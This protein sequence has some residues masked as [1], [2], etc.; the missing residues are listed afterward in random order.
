MK[1][2]QLLITLLIALFLV[3]GNLFIITQ[4]VRYL[5]GLGIVTVSVSDLVAV[6]AFILSMESLVFTFAWNYWHFHQTKDIHQPSPHL[7]LKER[8]VERDLQ[9]ALFV[10]DV[11]NR[12]QGDLS[13]RK[14]IFKGLWFDDER[15][16]ELEDKYDTI[17]PNGHATLRQKL[18]IPDSG[19]HILT[20]QFDM[21]RVIYKDDID[22][23]VS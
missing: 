4:F 3:L 9:S 12:G 6:A 8:I 15:I 7:K 17:E 16:Y 5:I 14:V 23:E 13:L 2:D 22:F 20:L 21:G 11:H 19:H 18:P 10:I 1:K